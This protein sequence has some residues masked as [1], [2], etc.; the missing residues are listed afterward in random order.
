MNARGCSQG[1]GC[2]LTCTTVAPAASAMRGIEAAGCTRPEVPTDS[3]T[4]HCRAAAKACSSTA[5][6][7]ISPNHTTPGR[8]GPAQQAQRGGSMRRPC[9]ASSGSATGSSAGRAQSRQRKAFSRPCKCSTARLPARS[10]R[11]STFCVTRVSF[12][13]C[14]ASAAMAR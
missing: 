8:N 14:A 11:S 9:T 13:T 7:N 2:G 3:S 1:T 6:G 12:G 4:S 10:C 5:S